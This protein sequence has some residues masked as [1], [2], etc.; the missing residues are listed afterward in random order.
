[1]KDKRYA[2]VELLDGRFTINMAPDNTVSIL[3]TDGVYDE[4][5]KDILVSEEDIMDIVECLME[6]R[7]FMKYE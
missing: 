2:C 3:V 7:T 5:A 4:H 6:I 1:M